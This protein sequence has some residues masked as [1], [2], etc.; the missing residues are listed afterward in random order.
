MNQFLLRGLVLI[1]LGVVLSW[2]VGFSFLFPPNSSELSSDQ[3]LT[4]TFLN[5]G[6]GDSTFI[7][8]AAGKQVLIDGGPDSAVLRELSSV[9]S[10]WDRTVDIVVG[11]HPDKDHIGGL[12]EV[13]S[14]YQVS[15]LLTTENRGETI[16][17]AA[18]QEAILDETGV[19]A[20]YARAGDIID[21]GDGVTLAV[22]SPAD[23]PALLESNT[24]SIVLQ[25]RYGGIEFMLT[26]DAPVG[27]EDYLVKAYG[28]ELLESEVLKLGHHGSQTSTGELFLQAVSPRYAVVS[29]GKDNSYGHPHPDVVARTTSFGSEILSTA[30]SG[31]ITFETDGISV[32]LAK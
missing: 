32:W 22:F 27:I 11:T 7:E 1:F 10:P 6:Q 9:M 24:A 3:N 21:L 12:V 26:G 30:E 4:V 2:G 15:T 17:S 20:W 29:A 23:N 8:T 5:I 16:I 31:R 19:A 18:Y 14:R 13:L 25:L 28:A